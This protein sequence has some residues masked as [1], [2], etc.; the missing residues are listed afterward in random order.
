MTS[1]LMLSS[2]LAA[3]R[4]ELPRVDDKCQ[5]LAKV[6]GVGQAMLIFLVSVARG[7][8][9]MLAQVGLAAAGVALAFAALAVLFALRPQLGNTGFRRYARMSVR[10]IKTMLAATAAFDP[11]LKANGA[12]TAEQVEAE[13][14]RVLS[15]I[16]DRKY[17]HLRVAVDLTGLAVTFLAFAMVAVAGVVA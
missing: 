14:L 4:E 16:V 1:N 12:A 3:V 15:Q 6:A 13:H 17:R 10:Q 11:D 9:P 2:E 8:M 5:A 7:S